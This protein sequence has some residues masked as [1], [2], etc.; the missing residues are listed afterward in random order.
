VKRNAWLYML[1]LAVLSSAVAVRVQA[2]MAAAS[3]SNGAP[4]SAQTSETTA[5]NAA[6]LLEGEQRFHTNC[7]RCHITP[8]KFPPR[9][10]AA[11][12]RHMRVRAMLTDEDMR[13]ILKYMTQ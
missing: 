4:A 6:M 2:L 13:L 7:G 12:I 10:M 1:L 9:M 8:H 11:I 3:Q 5:G